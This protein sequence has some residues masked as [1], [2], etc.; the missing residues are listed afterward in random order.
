MLLSF[1]N[2]IKFNDYYSTTGRTDFYKVFNSANA[3]KM[4]IVGN[5]TEYLTYA[6]KVIKYL[7]SNLSITRCKPAMEYL[8]MTGNADKY[9]SRANLLSIK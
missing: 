8:F 6:F 2:D 7:V 1:N 3:E 4:T 9:V 5:Q